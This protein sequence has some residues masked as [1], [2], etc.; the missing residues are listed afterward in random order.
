MSSRSTPGTAGGPLDGESRRR[1]RRPAAGTGSGPIT[2][3]SLE[4]ALRDLQADIDRETQPLLARV[5]CGAATAAGVLIA[6]AYW[7]GRRVGRGRRTVVEVRR[8]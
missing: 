4:D 3:E 2:R 1:W 5:A 7:Y 6:L 8:I